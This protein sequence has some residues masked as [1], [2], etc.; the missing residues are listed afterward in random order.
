MALK[1]QKYFKIKEKISKQK[2]R[3]SMSHVFTELF[4]AF[5]ICC[6]FTDS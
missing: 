1:R 6:Y 2:L 3:Q 4:T 5:F